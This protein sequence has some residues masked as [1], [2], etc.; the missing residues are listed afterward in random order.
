MPK[1]RSRVFSHAF[2]LAAVRRMMAGENV[3]ALSRELQILRK[4]LYYWR[5]RFRADGYLRMWVAPS[6]PRTR[7]RNA[8]GCAVL[9]ALSARDAYFSAVTSSCRL[10]TRLEPKDCRIAM[11]ATAMQAAI[12]PYSIAVAPVSSLTNLTSRPRMFN[13]SL[14]LPVPE[15]APRLALI[16][17]IRI[18][19]SLH[20]EH[21]L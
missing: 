4:D 9:C 7:F 14:L 2:K 16:L 11:I 18:R 15:N 13:A 17:L 3:S 19:R 1:R 21:G 5:T 6:Q 10:A 20:R 12:N 8:A